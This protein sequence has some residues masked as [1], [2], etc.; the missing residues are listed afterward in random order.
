MDCHA[1]GH[2]G[3]ADAAAGMLKDLKIIAPSITRASLEKMP[4]VAAAGDR[5]RHADG[6]A[7]GGL[8]S[9]PML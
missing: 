1:A 9:R 5:A 7:R 3:D 4:V 6:P 2:Q 8:D